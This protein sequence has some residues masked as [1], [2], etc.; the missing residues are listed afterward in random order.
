MKQLRAAVGFILVAALMTTSVLALENMSLSGGNNGTNV[1]SW[2]PTVER[3]V[4]G[5]TDNGQFRVISYFSW[6]SNNVN[7]VFDIP[8]DLFYTM[9]HNNPNDNGVA[10]LND[11]YSNLPYAEYDIDDDEGNGYEEELEVTCFSENDPEPLTAN[12]TYFFDTTW[13]NPAYPSK[14]MYCAVRSQRSMYS[15]F[16]GEMQAHATEFHGRT[17]DFMIGKETRSLMDEPSKIELE[18]ESEPIIISSNVKSMSD[19]QSHMQEQK[20]ALSEVESNNDL[21]ILRNAK[22]TVTFAEPLNYMTVNNIIR[23]TGANLERCTL[24]YEDKNGNRITGWTDDISASNLEAKLEYLR[25]AHGNVTYAGIVSANITMDLTDMEEYE[26]LV[27]NAS[28]Y[29]ADISDPLTRIEE[30]DYA[31]SLNLKVLDASW[32]LE[33]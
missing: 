10:T 4:R 2:S 17:D 24:K 20:I 33:K 13:H 6:N 25:E 15:R 14:E 31:G 9:E 7:D 32:Q 5:S 3:N 21:A 12:A 18:T 8:S 23:D 11:L 16:S 26:N 30:E 1:Y 28:V 22:V 29:F 19:A 27:N